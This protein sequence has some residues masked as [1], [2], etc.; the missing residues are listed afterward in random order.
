MDNLNFDYYK[1]KIESIEKEKKLSINKYKKKKIFK[2]N[3]KL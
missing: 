3:V 2:N 1:V